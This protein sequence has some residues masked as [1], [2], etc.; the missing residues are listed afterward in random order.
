MDRGTEIA[1][2]YSQQ[3]MSIRSYCLSKVVAKP[4]RLEKFN[5]EGVLS[6]AP[7]AEAG[8]Q[9]S[10]FRNAGPIQSFKQHFTTGK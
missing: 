4:I 6:P 2:W 9:V 5:M 7:N 1:T 8:T 3:K 10:L